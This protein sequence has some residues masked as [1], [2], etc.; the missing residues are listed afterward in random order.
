M[1]GTL[2]LITFVAIAGWF[3]QRAFR[4]WQVARAAEEYAEWKATQRYAVLK[5]L[6]PK[7]NE[8]T[9]QAAEQMFAALHGIYREGSP[10]QDQLSFELVSFQKFIHFYVHVPMH[11][12][13]FVEGQLYA[14]Y[15]NI[16]VTE[17]EDYSQL[18]DQNQSVAGAELVFTKDDVY[19]IQT[20]QNFTVD[21]LSSITAVLGSV[22]DREQLWVQ[23]IVKPV[24]D[25]WQDRGV[26]YV[27]AKRAGKPMTQPGPVRRFFGFLGPLLIE[28]LRTALQPGGAAPAEGGAGGGEEARVQLS[29]PEEAALK[30]IET[31][32][33]KLGFSTKMRVIAAAN[34]P[35]TARN[36][37]E[38]VTGAFKQFNLTNL[39]GFRS[40]PI[41]NNQQAI[42][43]YRTRLFEGPGM[44]MNT[45]ELASVFHLP[46][47]TVETPN[48]AWSGS[49]K[50]EPPSNLPLAGSI[51]ADE[52]T[53]LGET[54]FRAFRHQFGMKKRDR[55]LHMYSI[56]KTGT[57]KST[58]LL[59][60]IVDDIEKGRGVAVVDPH[61]QLVHD[62]LERIPNH[63]VND[64]LYFNPADRDFPVGF[65]LLENIDPDL[66]SVVASGV[67]S[68]FKKIFGES[69]G[70]RLEYILRNTVLA[71][72][73]Y[74]D[75]TLLGINRLLTDQ[76]YRRRVVRKVSD[77]VVRDYFE[78]EYERYDPK[79]QREAIAPIQNKVG[80]FLSSS[81]IRNLVGQPRSSFDIRQV[82]DSGK[83]L[84]VDL[85]IGK[86]GEDNASLLGSMI[87]TKIQLAAMSRA[88]VA[89]ADRRDFY[90]YVDEFQNFATDSFAVILSEARKYHLN[91]ML[92][93]QYIAQ[94]PENVAKAV[95][96]NVGTV[97]S[98]RVG[99]GDASGLAKE[100]EPVFDANDLVN[101][102]NYHTYVKMSIDGVT[103]PAF[104][105]K[106][107]P[108]PPIVE[109]GANVE[110]IIKVSRERYAKPRDFVE[111]K[112]QEWSDDVQV[113]QAQDWRRS[114]QEREAQ[115]TGQQA[116]PTTSGAA[117]VPFR[118][119]RT[120]VPLRREQGQSKPQVPNVR[121]QP[122]SSSSGQ[123][124]PPEQGRGNQSRSADRRPRPQ[125][126]T[127]Q[128]RG[129]QQVPRTQTPNRPNRPPLSSNGQRP[130][131]QGSTRSP[132]PVQP[133]ERTQSGSSNTGQ[134]RGATSI[135]PAREFFTLHDEQSVRPQGQGSS[136]PAKV[137]P[138]AA[139]IARSLSDDDIASLRDS[140]EHRGG[141]LVNDDETPLTPLDETP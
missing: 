52:M 101:L 27:S 23:M 132:R 77:P 50:G 14:Q 126:N 2:I 22:S 65:N 83:I 112:I 108:P 98:F 30:G 26:K 9:P 41:D 15:P 125:A 38:A 105:A 46:S 102:G 106:M 140:E 120:D 40:L 67:V 78:N 18:L 24:A 91:L 82:M 28:F 128:G 111:Q 88:D 58:L 47:V 70:P 134:G 61:G 119:S 17:T 19:P 43:S 76:E 31:K 49:K 141:G 53:I 103:R 8:K 20:F 1:T 75:T 87:I 133:H 80:Q 72:L 21:P 25:D 138:P 39:N 118:D 60:M 56:G 92:T 44:V 131:E 37:I 55:N 81:T 42:Q 129:A 85:S 12:R 64:V 117:T 127:G 110:K 29:A 104:S 36:K 135:T 94:M 96:G 5:I 116:K 100:F 74:P 48:I 122:Q 51:P 109:E 16:E 90:L 33:T 59:N 45:E 69:W 66:R 99:P 68:I 139:R 115:A 54:D 63:R 93:N 6:V 123:H 124:R 62:V 32:V 10:F 136:T 84:L 3:G 11:L 73:H 4:Q 95:F 86:I 130:P 121:V 35:Y 89:E 13:E 34:D 113:K 7:N 71:L 57:G 97:I 79:F 114:V 137:Q 107:L